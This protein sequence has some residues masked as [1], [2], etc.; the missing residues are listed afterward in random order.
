M[1]RNVPSCQL[2]RAEFVRA[3]E[4]DDGEI[5]ALLRTVPMDGK[6]QIGFEREPSYD[7]C[8][9]PAGIEENTLVARRY[10]KLLSVGS[11]SM[12]D[13]WL[14]GEPKCIG[15][16]HGLRMAP[17]TTGSMRVLRDGY[18]RLAE[19]VKNKAAVGWFT[20]VDANNTRARRVFESRASGLP[21][22]RRMAEYLTR[23][24]PVPRQ[25]A[26]LRESAVAEVDVTEF[27]QSEGSRHDL[28]LIWN[29]DRWL[30]LKR[31]GFTLDNVSVVRREGRIVAVAGVWDQSA[32]KQIVIHGYPTWMQRLRPLLPIVTKCLGWPGLP[33]AGCRVPL[34]TVFPFAVARG[35][36]H[37][38]AELWCGVESIARA[39]GIEWL[40]LGLDASDPLWQKVRMRR[41]GLSYRTIL[42]SV[43]G[44]G[45]PNYEWES[46]DRIFRPECATL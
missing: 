24:M 17:G 18:A 29:E 43:S 28:A 2:S 4:A 19:D 8:P 38:L 44:K 1:D 37:S 7:A 20:S 3:T 13:V 23:V 33:S 31:N 5:R 26:L 27:L 16:L 10:G 30:A 35:E 42:Y 12:R 6:L 22:Y 46:G 15:Y 45:F 34:A 21:H 25:G 14:E 41:A 9:A 36:E 11:W 40:G 39:K 32:W